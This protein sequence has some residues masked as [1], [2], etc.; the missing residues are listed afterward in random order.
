M[1]TAKEKY[2]ALANKMIHRL[3]IAKRDRGLKENFGQ[4]ELLIYSTRVMFDDSILYPERCK[5]VASLS[6][7][8]DALNTL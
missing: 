5:M 4:R 8:I 2:E 3:E 1:K 7:R 6:N